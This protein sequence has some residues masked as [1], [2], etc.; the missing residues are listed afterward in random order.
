[1]AIELRMFSRAHGLVRAAAVVALGLGAASC[2]LMPKHEPMPIGLASPYGGSGDVIWAVAPFR[3][4]SATSLA[5]ELVL[6]DTLRNQ[7]TEVRGLSA[8]PVN[9]T[10][11]AMRTLGMASVDTPGEARKLAAALGVD[12][13]VVGSITSWQ[14]YHPP[15]LGLNLVLFA[16]GSAMQDASFDPVAF[17]TSAVDVTM[18]MGEEPLSA[19][20]MQLDGA[21]NDVRCQVMRYAEGRHDPTSALGAERYL[22]SMAEFEKFACFRA[23]ELLL[24]QERQRLSRS[25]AKQEQASAR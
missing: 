12:A 24:E 20:S 6:A 7:L 21:S 25:P 14:P 22:K 2:S 1:M 10:I 3:N 17:T 23:T 4:E 19:V 13:I 9:R 18:P 8:L 5:N 16:N 11:N 15:Q